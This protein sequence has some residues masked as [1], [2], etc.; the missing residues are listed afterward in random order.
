MFA[1]QAARSRQVSAGWKETSE[2][3]D[4]AVWWP[5]KERTEDQSMK[6]MHGEIRL[7]KDLMPSTSIAH[8]TVDVGDS[9][10]CLFIK[11]KKLCWKYSVVVM[12]FEAAYFVSSGA[13]GEPLISESVELATN[14]APG[15]APKAYAPPG[16]NYGQRPS[17][18]SNIDGLYALN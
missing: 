3:L 18:L 7:S 12:P 17:G 11:L 15:P 8:F 16:Y 9:F 4:G 13:K 6:R 14:R 10:F 1:S 2:F 5:V